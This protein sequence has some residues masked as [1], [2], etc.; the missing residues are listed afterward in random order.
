MNSASVTVAIALSGA[1]FFIGFVFAWRSM[2]K[3]MENEWK[4]VYEMMIIATGNEYE[5]IHPD[6]NRKWFVSKVRR[7]IGAAYLKKT[8]R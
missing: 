5:K 8:R 6:A 4:I 7:A 2:K 1:A 3:D